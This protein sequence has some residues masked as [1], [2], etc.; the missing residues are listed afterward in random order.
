MM[1][2]IPLHC[3]GSS[4]IGIVLY[5][6]RWFLCL[7]PSGGGFLRS[8]WDGASPGVDCRPANGQSVDRDYT[9]NIRWNIRNDVR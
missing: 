2:D 9:L 1:L 8:A 4:M 5:E 7:E 3:S 6:E